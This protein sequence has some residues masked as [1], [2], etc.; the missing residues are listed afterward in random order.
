VGS[1]GLVIVSLQ[2]T[3]VDELASLRIFALLDDVMKLLA[4]ELRLPEAIPIPVACPSGD[5]D[6]FSELPYDFSG[7]HSPH[8][9]STLDL[10]L[11]SRLKVTQGS[12]AGCSGVVAGKDPEGHYSV[13]VF[14]DVGD[15]ACIEEDLL[16]G[17]WWLREAKLGRVPVLPVLQE[18]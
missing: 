11:G 2:E 10:R 8:A 18:T 12:F 9:S 4:K 16:L 13:K 7:Q 6:V 3:Q 1:L 5:P 17:S 14:M 15:G